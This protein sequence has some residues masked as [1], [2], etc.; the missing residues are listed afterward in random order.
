MAR[1]FASLNGSQS[2]TS[3]NTPANGV[4]QWTVSLTAR[5]PSMND[6]SIARPCS[7]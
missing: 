5:N 6:C 2:R 7:E 4:Y 3:E 1:F